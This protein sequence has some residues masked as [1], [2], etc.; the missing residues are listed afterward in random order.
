MTRTAL[1]LLGSPRIERD[2]EPVRVDTRKAIALV[3][4]LA[5]TRRRSGR[6]TLAA[7]LWPEYGQTKARAALRRTLSVLNKALAEDWLEADRESVGLQRDKIRV[8]VDRFRGLLAECQTH[9]HPPSETC[10][11]CLPLLA[12]A[13]TLYRGDFLA[14]FNLR[15]SP[16]FDDWQFFEAQSLRRELSDALQRLVRG[17]AER[18]EWESAI[19]YARRWLALDPLHEPAHRSLMQL[20]AWADQRTDALR[21]YREC[22]RVLERELGVQPLEETTNLYRSIKESRIPPPPAASPSRPPAP[23]AKKKSTPPVRETA[24]GTPPPENPLVGRSEEHAAL[25]RAYEA[26]GARGHAVVLEGEAGIGKTRLAEELLAHARDWGA[27]IVSAR[28]YPGEENLAYGPFVEGLSAAIG[29]GDRAARLE[30][31]PA[32]ALTEAAR[33]L[34]ELAESHPELS[35]PPPLDTPG[36]QSRFFEGISQVLLM[37]CRGEQPGV[38]FVD[39]LHWADD[40]SLDLLAYLVRRLHGRPLCVLLTWR[41]EEISSDHRLRG[42]LAEARRAGTAT[43]LTLPRMSPSAVEELARSIASKESA[44]LPDG[45]GKRLYEETEGLPLFVQEYLTAIARG[46]LPSGT[47]DWSLPGGVRDLLHG[48][49]QGISETGWQLLTSAAAIGRSFD[50][51]TA[52]EVSGRSEEETVAALEELISQGLVRGVGGGA[53]EP[54]LAYDFTHEKL[55]A[56]VYEET[57]LVRRRLLHRR[58]AEALPARA[59]GGRELGALAGQ[60]AQHYRLAGQ[61]GEAADY[62]KL[63]GEHARALYANKDALAHF[64]TALALGHSD[65]A[66]LREAVGDMHTLLG[67]YGAALASYESAAALRD[68]EALAGVERKLGNVYQRR[69]EW[70]LAEGH[71]EAALAALGESGPAGERAKLYAARSLNAYHRDHTGGAVKL[72]RRALELAERGGDAPALAQAH[73]MLGM[74]AGGQ[75]D[76]VRGRRHLER[77]LELA[78][79]LDDPGMRAAALNNLALAYKS[80]GE[81]ERAIERAQA[82]LV[83]CV[84]Q[85]DRHREA[86]LHNNLADLLHDAGRTEEALSH[87]KQS[88]TIYADIGVEGGAVRPEIWKLAEW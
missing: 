44:D 2:G 63:A 71:Y 30:E 24:L 85:G 62:F 45:L 37:V 86:A 38:L 47:T 16:N 26:T 68:D 54:T 61:E 60:I 50:F 80:A 14:G 20:Y 9:E 73:N 72:G 42:L 70:E 39:D 57:S 21:Q 46:A 74:L 15:D 43:L 52:R 87:L 13:V 49:L 22:V 51:D 3:A 32:H 77:S 59:H 28:C 41:G 5:V 83:L 67:E 65:V 25:V 29:Q 4:H 81:T 64:R 55:R 53:G 82:A 10:P 11:A 84:S 1:L 35:P 69:G 18:G 76:L 31:L 66:A 36:A 8:D 12:E 27:A 48:R 23:Q 58:V 78:E 17:H 56:L 34:P 6:D 79:T 40:A 19:A 7:L 33:L 88:V 75:G